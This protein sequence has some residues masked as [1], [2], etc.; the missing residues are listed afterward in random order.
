MGGNGRQCVQL[1]ESAHSYPPSLGHRGA[2]SS[3]ST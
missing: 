2:P 1:I 3:T